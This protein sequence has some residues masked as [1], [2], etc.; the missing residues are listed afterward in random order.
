MILNILPSCR[1]PAT[2]LFSPV[3]AGERRPPLPDHA[4]A[5]S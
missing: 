4:E 3:V 1:K 5:P 2:G